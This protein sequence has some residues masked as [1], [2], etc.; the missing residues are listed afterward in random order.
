MDIFSSYLFPSQLAILNAWVGFV[1]GYDINIWLVFISKS[2]DS[3]IPWNGILTSSFFLRAIIMTAP[4][5]GALTVS[6][7][8][9]HG[10][11]WIGRRA[12][13][14][15][16]SALWI[17][18][19]A[20]S[21]LT[22]LCFAAQTN[23]WNDIGFILLVSGRLVNGMANGLAWHAAPLWSSEVAPTYCRGFVNVWREVAL[24][25]GAMSAWCVS[26]EGDVASLLI[27][28]PAAAILLLATAWYIPES[29]RWLLLQRLQR[30][31]RGAL[32]VIHK[33]QAGVTEKQ[34]LSVLVRDQQRRRGGSEWS[35]IDD[36]TFDE[37]D[38]AE[39]L[40]PSLSHESISTRITALFSPRLRR[41][42]HVA[43]GL[44]VAQQFQGR[45]IAAIVILGRGISRA[46]E[47]SNELEDTPDFASTVIFHGTFALL[48]TVLSATL[49]DTSLFGRRFLLLAGGTLT[50][51]AAVLLIIFRFH[52]FLLIAATVSLVSGYALGIFPL[53]VLLSSE[54]FPLVLRAQGMV[55][56][57][58]L[59]FLI[60]MSS[61]ML[62][63]LSVGSEPPPTEGLT[64]ASCAVAALSF[65]SISF[66]YCYVPETK[67]Q[68]L[69][70]IENT[71]MHP[72]LVSCATNKFEEKEAY[73]RGENAEELSFVDQGKSTEHAAL[74]ARQEREKKLNENLAVI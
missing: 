28:V 41:G 61:T 52:P 67:G 7:T 59:V 74:I 39:L 16:A 11:D 37:G 48:F 40:P 5:I 42:T 19:G 1:I 6:L 47:Q 15:I 14:L 30:D 68:T 23:R 71:W 72:H 21:R 53:A 3:G 32:E 13:L 56:C 8:N 9:I 29:P 22:C 2:L 65:G 46:D 60:D 12:E 44:L 45:C 18:G 51:T 31:A 62:Y 73:L 66:I 49:V 26:K 36:S 58:G 17:F 69:E 54:L 55:L 38:V 4:P 63:S 50:L 64:L 33:D 25:F 70:E 27:I 24:V 35:Q 34:I 20:L 57:G 10:N 43:L